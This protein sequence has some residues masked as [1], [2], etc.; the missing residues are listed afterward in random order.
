MFSFEY[1]ET[2][3]KRVQE[4]FINLQNHYFRLE[5][6]SQGVSKALDNCGHG[7]IIWKLDKKTDRSKINAL[8]TENAQLAM[9]VAAMTQ[10]LAQKSEEMCRYQAK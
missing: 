1:L 5:H 9:H 10:E 2:P 4:E 3:F 6:I 8:E 7:N